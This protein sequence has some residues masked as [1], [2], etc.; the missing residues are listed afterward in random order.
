MS[1]QDNPY[2][3]PNERIDG[4]GVMDATGELSICAPL[5][6]SAGWMKFIGVMF[7]ILGGFSV[8]TIW[9]II[10]AW[11]PIWMGVVLVKSAKELRTGYAAKNAAM[12]TSAFERL[13]VFF[14]IFGIIMIVYACL[15]PIAIIAAIAIP[16]MLSSRGH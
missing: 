3:T 4:A 8:L 7:I 13:R 11:V 12:C 15:L 2:S 6:R 10:F 9:G 14:K 1:M 5:V 16:S